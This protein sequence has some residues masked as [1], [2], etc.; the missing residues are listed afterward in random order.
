MAKTGGIVPESVSVI[1]TVQEQYLNRVQQVVQ[2]LEN[3]G[4]TVD[5]VLGTLGQVIGHA[6]EPRVSGLSGVS[7]VESVVP[8]RR[9]VIAPPESGIQ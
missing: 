5:Q 1:I 7:G 9:I 3:V 8:E 4:L 6:T 2:E